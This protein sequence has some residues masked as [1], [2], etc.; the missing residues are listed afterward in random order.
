M[1]TGMF[2]GLLK[3]ICPSCPDWNFERLHVFLLNLCTGG[4]VILYFTEGRARVTPP[5]ALFFSGSVAYAVCAFLEF[6]TAAV[7]IAI[8]LAA[9]VER[10]RVKRFSFFPSEFFSMR[11]STAAKFHQAAL[12]CLSIGLL[13]SAFVIVNS[14]FLHLVPYPRLRLDV[15][16]LGFSF[17]VSLVTLSMMFILIQENGGE[18]ARRFGFSIFWGV[19]AGVLVFFGFILVEA[20]IA[21][22]FISIFL[23]ATVIVMFFL[24]LARS[25]D[26]QKRTIL[27]SGMA[28]ILLTGVTGVGYVALK[29]LGYDPHSWQPASLLSLHSFISL[30]GWNLCGLLL[31]VRA[32]E[33]PLG[34]DMRS[35]LVQH[36]IVVLVLAPCGRYNAACAAVA[37]LGFAALLYQYLFTPGSTPG[38]MQ[39]I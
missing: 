37:A 34:I 11:S 18:G 10:V 33:F 3:S 13:V 28:F 19:N 20:V 2:M 7:V 35:F 12:L 17:P 36:W 1:T 27:A 26:G 5:V 21:Q 6:Y 9:V 25:R 24:F 14:E 32:G 31:I 30:Y 23:F 22:L 39:N 29:M 38:K 4:S 8:L 15:F 16:F